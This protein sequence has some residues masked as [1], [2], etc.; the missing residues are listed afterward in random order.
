MPVRTG[1][2]RAIAYIGAGN[3][4]RYWIYVKL[5]LRLRCGVGRRARTGRTTAKWQ[6]VVGRR[7]L[8]GSVSTS[9]IKHAPRKDSEEITINV[10]EIAGGDDII[11][12]TYSKPPGK[13]TP[14]SSVSGLIV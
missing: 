11:S 9:C 6:C 2:C 12:K 5:L 7:G 4:S 1:R 3:K 8:E 14:K 10:K 13:V